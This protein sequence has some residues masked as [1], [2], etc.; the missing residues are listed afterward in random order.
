MEEIQK[1]VDALNKSP[2]KKDSMNFKVTKVDFQSMLSEL[3]T[4]KDPISSLCTLYSMCLLDI[5]KYEFMVDHFIPCVHD[6]GIIMTQSSALKYISTLT[7]YNIY[8]YEIFRP[9][10]SNTN[11]SKT[12]LQYF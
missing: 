6:A 1:I 3:S 7:K 12:F 5:E 4:I 8:I 2:E 11:L 9:R 10:A